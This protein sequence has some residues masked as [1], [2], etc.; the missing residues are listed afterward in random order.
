M[1]PRTSRFLR[2]SALLLSV[3]VAALLLPVQELSASE[4]NDGIK[5]YWAGAFPA[6]ASEFDQLE[7]K[8]DKDYVLYLLNGAM[9]HISAGDFRHAER[10]LMAAKMTFEKEITEGEV[11]GQVLVSDAK[12]TYTGHA[13]EKVLTCFLL[14]LCQYM[15][16]EYDQARIGFMEA[17]EADTGS[18]EEYEGDVAYVHYMLGKTFMML[19]QLD[20]AKVAMR[21]VG[22]HAGLTALADFG[23]AQA[24]AMEGRASE[25]ERLMQDYR[26]NDKCQPSGAHVECAGYVTVVLLNGLSPKRG[27]DVVTGAFTT[28]EERA[29][30]EKSARFYV[31]D[32]VVGCS[33]MLT[34]LL[35]QAETSGGMGEQ[36]TSKAA[37]TLAR[38]G[39]A[40]LAGAIIPGGGCLTKQVLGGDEADVRY[41]AT[42]PGDVQVCEVAMPPGLHTLRIE[43]FDAKDKELPRY[44][45]VWYY[46]HAD[47]DE[48]RTLVVR[49]MLDIHNQTKK[50]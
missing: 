48:P 29:Y 1:T 32:Q 38:K 35:H 42:A 16:G 44:E 11:A 40:S 15:Q 49:S 24:A 18:R 5:A 6:A 46:I 34:D 4:L 20:D 21:N 7:Q 47:A 19:R 43:F 36:F 37:G 22:R 31:D 25:A 33:H 39:I 28:I 45:Q 3:A 12:K 23:L 26:A 8:K 14:G 30:P 10:V 50:S 41:W 17:L 9:A 13:Y 27:A 2:A